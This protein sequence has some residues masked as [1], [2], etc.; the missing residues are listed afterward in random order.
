MKYISLKTGG[1]FI[2][3]NA[4]A[5]NDAFKQLNQENLQFL[6]IKNGGDVRQTYPSMPIN[7]D[8]HFAVAGILNGLNTEFV[9]QFGYGSTVVS[10]QPVRLNATE[11]NLSSIDISRVWAQ[12][13]IAE[14]DI[15]YDANKDDISVLSKQ[16]GIVTRNTSLIVLENL[17]DYLRYDIIPPVELRQAYEAALKQRRISNQER[18]TDLLNAAVAMTKEL[19]TWW[20]TDFDYKIPL[21][22]PAQYP[23][24]DGVI[25]SQDNVAANNSSRNERSVHKLRHLLYRL[26]GQTLM[27]E[28]H[29]QK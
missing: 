24:P 4:L 5:T 17:T 14:M 8:G 6:G 23:T 16:F 7:V 29:L 25:V 1:Q 27:I 28:R 13:K 11:H 20:N 10:E 3:L 19:K 2:N 9:L 15:Q 18:K 12:K 22:K 26:P 21:G